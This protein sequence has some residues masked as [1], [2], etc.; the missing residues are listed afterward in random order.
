MIE[1][2]YKEEKIGT[3]EA[4]KLKEEFIKMRIKLRDCG[5]KM[6]IIKLGNGQKFEILDC[7]GNTVSEYSLIYDR[8]IVSIYIVNF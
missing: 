4:N 8:Y 7:D 2:L 5:L 3:V 1:K 6:R